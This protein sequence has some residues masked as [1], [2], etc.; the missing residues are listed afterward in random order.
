MYVDAPL[1]EATRMV[2]RTKEEAQATRN[3]IL[4]TAEMAFHEHGVSRTSLQD[5]AAAAGVTRGA[6]YWHFRDKG[7]LF[8][9]MMERVVLPL[10]GQSAHEGDDP[11]AAMRENFIAALRKTVADPQVRRV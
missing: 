4:D 8:N 7:E 10:E 6:I 1:D 2:R 11:L 5:I 3:R 9:A